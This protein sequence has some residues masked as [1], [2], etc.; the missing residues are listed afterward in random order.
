[1]H[2]YP[3]NGAAHRVGNTDTPWSCRNT[4]FSEVIVAVDADPAKIEPMRRWA[5]EYWAALHPHS[6]GGSLTPAAPDV[7]YGCGRIL[8]K[9][10]FAACCISSP[11]I[12]RRWVARLQV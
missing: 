4:N 9:N 7:L 10:S 12:S 11:V 3:I 1:M 6:S 8:A 5:R 2:L